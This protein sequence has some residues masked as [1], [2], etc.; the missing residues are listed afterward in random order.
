M[1]HLGPERQDDLFLWRYM[2]TAK[3][4]TVILSGSL[5]LTRLDHF[6]DDSEGRF[7]DP[8]FEFMEKSRDA[9]RVAFKEVTGAPE[10]VLDLIFENVGAVGQEDIFRRGTCA[11]SWYT[12]EDE[13]PTMWSEYGDVAIKS[14]LGLLDASLRN[15]P[16]M[17]TTGEVAYADAKQDPHFLARFGAQSFTKDAGTYRHEN[18]IRLT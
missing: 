6:T 4:V 5:H 13:D 7:S 9:L 14:R 18:E 3:F 15:E 10:G 8:A 16:R 12:G 11:C 17:L 2:D 1:W